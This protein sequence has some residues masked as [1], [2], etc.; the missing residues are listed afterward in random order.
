[1]RHGFEIP[2]G[3]ENR[4]MQA[5][6]STRTKGQ[7]A[8][9]FLHQK[10]RE[11]MLTRSGK[12]M[13][14]GAL[15]RFASS[16]ASAVWSRARM[17]SSH[18]VAALAAPRGISTAPSTIRISVRRALP[19]IASRS[20]FMLAPRC[21]VRIEGSKVNEVKRAT[22]VSACVYRPGNRKVKQS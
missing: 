7:G 22:W 21:V 13:A 16:L 2:V 5:R 1:M 4:Q 11:K 19:V 20:L 17:P 14:L 8:T 18:Q 9:F 12:S 3:V 10:H 15:H 6:A